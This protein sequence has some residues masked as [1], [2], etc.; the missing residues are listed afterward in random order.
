MDKLQFNQG[1][2]SSIADHRSEPVT[3]FFQFITFMGGVEGYLILIA[4]LFAA[5]SKRQAVQSSIVVLVAMIANHLMKILIQNPRPFVSDGTYLAQWAVSPERAVELVAEYSTP[6][7]HAMAAAAFYL[8]LVLQTENVMIR[9]SLIVAAILV[10]L[11]RPILGVHYVEDILLG[12]LIGGGMAIL[13]NFY[14]DKLWSRWI[15]VPMGAQLGLTLILGAV[16]WFATLILTQRPIA[17]LP[18]EFVGILGFLTGVLLAAPI[19]ATNFNYSPLGSSIA[20]KLARFVVM[21][22]VLVGSLLVFDTLFSFVGSEG[23]FLEAMLRFTKYA[24]VG[25]AGIL[26]APWLFDRLRLAPQRSAS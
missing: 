16:I 17:E 25:V 24:A 8:F 11:S 13:A 10:G 12:W 23:T 4:I 19:E 5:I 2:L 26:G 20:V 3:T 1:L 7:G 18:T 21:M 9:L 22:T 14:I 15:A 6:S